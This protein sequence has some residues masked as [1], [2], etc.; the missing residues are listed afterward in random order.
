MIRRFWQRMSEIYGHRWV[1]SY[2]DNAGGAAARTWASGLA[3]LAGEQIA[4][5]ISGC[6]T[7]AEPWPPTL[8][9]FRRLCLE[10]PTRAEVML[11]LRRSNA[12]RAPFTRLVWSMIPHYEFRRD[13]TDAASRKVNDAYHLAVAHVMAG[14]EIPAA[15]AGELTAEPPRPPKPA[16]PEVAKAH[17]AEIAA[18]LGVDAPDTEQAA[19]A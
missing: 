7:S 3:G 10:I 19:A 2:G 16:D 12:E 9:E 14:G 13:N 11:D 17:M 15:P 5:G 18:S 6:M 4:R 8:P 1:S